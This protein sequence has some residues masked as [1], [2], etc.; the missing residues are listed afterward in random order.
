MV[1]AGR[2]ATQLGW[3]LKEAGH[4]VVAVWSRT[5]ESAEMLASQL[6]ATA[7]NELQRLPLQADVFVVSVKDVALES[8]VDEAV[9]GRGTQLFLHTAGSMAMSIFHGKTTRYGVLYPMQTFS[10]ERRVDFTQIPVFI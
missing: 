8:V 7:T 10:K 6:G 1:G 9:K 5:M 3:A 2:L 4:D